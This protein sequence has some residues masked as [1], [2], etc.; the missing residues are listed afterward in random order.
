[1]KKINILLLI[2]TILLTAFY[3]CK[4]EIIEPTL[5]AYIPAKTDANG[6][7]WKTYILTNPT[8]V[9]IAEPKAITSPEY[10][11]ELGVLKGIWTTNLSAE[12]KAA[13][14]YW[15]AGSVYRW[16]EIARELCAKYNIIIQ[17]SLLRIRLMQRVLWHI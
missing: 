11:L 1:M 6:G 3:A 12:K 4:K 13:V 14:T 7:I 5:D 17:N 10:Q 9:T 8:D 15:G 16:N 2:I